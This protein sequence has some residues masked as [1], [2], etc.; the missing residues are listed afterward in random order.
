MNRDVAVV[1]LGLRRIHLSMNYWF[2]TAVEWLGLEK[3]SK[4]RCGVVWICGADAT[5]RDR[6][7]V[8][9]L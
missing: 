3:F 4:A 8:G 1:G 2:G 5:F 7:V 9:G 6:G